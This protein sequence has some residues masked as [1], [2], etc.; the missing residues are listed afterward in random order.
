MPTLAMTRRGQAWL[1]NFREEDQPVA[2][3]LLDG[4][5]MVSDTQF[6]RE[7]KNL[8]ARARGD[9]SSSTVA[10]YAVH[11]LPKR[12]APHYFGCERPHAPITPLVC[13][14]TAHTGSEMIVQNILAKTA[15]AL[16]I[17]VDP[18]VDEMY[19]SQV[20]RVLLVTDNVATGH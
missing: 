8:I 16:K 10:A 5:E 12:F 14:T 13:P 9:E 1:G 6:R 15:N 7:M 4:L 3:R 2:R 18:T 19:A 20:D 11:N 17:A